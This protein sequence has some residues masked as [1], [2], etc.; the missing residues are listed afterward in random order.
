[1]ARG[2]AHHL[3]DR[4]R[5]VRARNDRDDRGDGHHDCRVACCAAYSKLIS[6]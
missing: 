5:D 6:L 1:M 3:R 2:Y 4:V